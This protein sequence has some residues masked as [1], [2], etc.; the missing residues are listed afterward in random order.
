[1]HRTWRAPIRPNGPRSKMV[2]HRIIQCGQRGS[3]LTTCGLCIQDRRTTDCIRI[4][5]TRR[6][7]HGGQVGPACGVGTANRQS[8]RACGMD[9]KGRPRPCAHAISSGPSHPGQSETTGKQAEVNGAPPY[10]KLTENQTVHR[11]GM[12][13]QSGSIAPTGSSRRHRCHRGEGSVPKTQI[14]RIYT[15]PGRPGE[16]EGEAEKE[17][18]TSR[19]RPTGSPTSADDG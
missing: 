4:P 2:L 1:M 16:T 5:D 8:R 7:T 15:I 17:V 6:A 18:A 11:C 9:W 19:Q 10:S 3:R 13:E 14:Q 12:R